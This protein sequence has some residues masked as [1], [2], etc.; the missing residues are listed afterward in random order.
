MAEKQFEKL[1][2]RE[3]QILDVLYE[4]GEASAQDVLS[5]I[6]DPP[7][8]SSVRALLARMLEKRVVSFRP[9]GT[10]HIYSAVVSEQKAQGSALQRLVK[11][12]FKGSRVNAMNAL[13]DMDDTDISPRE[14]A[15][16]E[17]KISRLK[18]KLNT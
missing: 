18:S 14:L 5:E 17:R 3:R 4:R 6:P 15:E 2:R 10:K 16:I 9:H 7:S 1:S 12:F 8:Y 11:I 13:L